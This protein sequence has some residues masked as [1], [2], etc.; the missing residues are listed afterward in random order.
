KAEASELIN[1]AERIDKSV[2]KAAKILL[3]HDGKVVVCGIGKSGLIGQKIVATFCSTGTQAVFLHASNALHGDLGIYSPGDPT[4]LISKSGAT[5]EVV[6]LIPLLREFN[7][8]LIGIIG[9]MDS[10]LAE[11]VDVVLDSTV[12]SEADPLGVV[13]TNSTTVTMAIGDALAAVLMTAKKFNQED[14][15]RFHPGGNLGRRLKLQVK[16]ILTVLDKVAV[17]SPEQSLMEAVLLMTKKPQG[18]ALVSD[19]SKKLFGIIT[20]GDLRRGFAKNGN[21]NELIVSDVMKKKPIF[22]YSNARLQEAV[23]LMEDRIS[24]ISVLPVLD[25]NND[26]CIGLL[27]LH[28][29]YQSKL[30]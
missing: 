21:I 13:P 25:E 4:I 8:P 30:I 27:R 10:T 7:S 19:G 6:R 2:V 20:D 28:D 9:N 24:Q 15:A 12:S 26:K 29:I 14:F 3:K 11:K 22:I 16:D 18:A 5:D 17:V 23:T 1:V